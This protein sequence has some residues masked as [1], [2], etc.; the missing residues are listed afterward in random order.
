MII[1]MV[2][3][4]VFKFELKCGWIDYNV[5]NIIVYVCFVIGLKIN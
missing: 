5:E 4:N 2:K 1:N 3:D